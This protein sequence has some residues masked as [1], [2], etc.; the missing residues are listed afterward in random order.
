LKELIL[1]GARSGK[2]ALAERR[3][4]E[5][6]LDVVYLATAQALDGEM[7]ERVRRHRER[8][9][10]AWALEEEPLTL[11]ACLSRSA[12]PRRCVLVD[13]VTLWLANLLAESETFAEHEQSELL[14]ILPNL[15]GHLI[16]VSN[17][18]GLGIVP[19]NALARRFRDRAGELHQRLANLCQRVTVT[20]AGLPWELK[21]E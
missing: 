1:G 2:S 19:D 15:P 8:R 14:R 6:G 11:A 7:A 13:C 10:R 17:E 21:S 3:A 18:V 16:L 4:L 12:D 20:V 5:S 9:P